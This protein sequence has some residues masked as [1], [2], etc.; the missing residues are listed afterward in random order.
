M[1]QYPCTVAVAERTLRPCGSGPH[2]FGM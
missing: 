1:Y 2:A